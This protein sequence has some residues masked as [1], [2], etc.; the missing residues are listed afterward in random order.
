MLRFPFVSHPV[1][2]RKHISTWSYLPACQIRIG[3]GGQKDGGHV[4]MCGPW[5][6]VQELTPSPA[7]LLHSKIETMLVLYLLQS[8]YAAPSPLTKT[9]M[10]NFYY[11]GKATATLF[12]IS[13]TWQYRTRA[14]SVLP[15]EEAMFWTKLNSLKILDSMQRF[16]DSIQPMHLDVYGHNRKSCRSLPVMSQL[17]I[18]VQDTRTTTFY[19]AFTFCG[20]GK[21]YVHL[22]HPIQQQNVAL[23]V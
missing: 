20:G 22:P 5:K 23:T 18:S 15:Q 4:H 1:L 11:A 10:F 12:E 3:F 21:L 13:R 19:L 14:T 9:K 16:W 17:L 8:G 6:M 7:T 2:P